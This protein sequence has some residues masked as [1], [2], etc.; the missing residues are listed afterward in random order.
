MSIINNQLRD[1]AGV[2]IQTA[3]GDVIVGAG[4]ATLTN[5]A[6]GSNNQALTANSGQTSGVAWA[7]ILLPA[8]NL[9]D[10]SNATTTQQN[11][12]FR[13]TTPS[14]FYENFQGTVAA[15][16]DK[17]T[18]NF[19]V[20]PGDGSDNYMTSA[21]A[22][23]VAG[24]PDSGRAGQI[25]LTAGTGAYAFWAV[26]LASQTLLYSGVYVKVPTFASNSEPFLTLKNGGINGTHLGRLQLGGSANSGKIQILNDADAVQATTTN[27][28]TAGSWFRVDWKVDTVGKTQTLKL[29]TGANLHSITPTETITGAVDSAGSTIDFFELGPTANPGTP[30]TYNI[31]FARV[32]VRNDMYVGPIVNSLA[33]LGV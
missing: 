7:N 4:P 6:V 1:V 17:T 5:V 20:N 15:V 26:T 27:V 29:F 12:G 18:T 10:V 22:T 30:A 9:S 13:I 2:P 32:V 19:T 3:I 23:F 8:N 14:L 31:Q 11:L 25:A 21:C 16:A 24:G 28:I 33:Y